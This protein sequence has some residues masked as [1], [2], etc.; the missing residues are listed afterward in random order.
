MTIAIRGGGVSNAIKAFFSNI[1]L[2][3]LEPKRFLLKESDAQEMLTKNC[4]FSFGLGDK[5]VSARFAAMPGPGRR[6]SVGG[7]VPNKRWQDIWNCKKCEI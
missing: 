6:V 1:F 4:V 3:P 5:T 7:G 2:N